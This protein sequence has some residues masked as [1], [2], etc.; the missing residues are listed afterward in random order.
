VIENRI[1]REKKKDD[2]VLI[3]YRDEIFFFS[4]FEHDV[5]KKIDLAQ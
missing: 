5:A 1:G 2:I 3:F 4:L